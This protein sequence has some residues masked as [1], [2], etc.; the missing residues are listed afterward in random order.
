MEV[1]EMDAFA[2][3]KKLV[4]LRGEKTQEEVA[5]DLGIATSTLSM[6]EN[7][8]RIPRDNIKL[9]IAAYY[10]EPIHLIFFTHESH[11]M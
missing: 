6:Y 1:L 10:G 5:K 8:E 4:K 2:I 11:E 7:G 9:R 3:G